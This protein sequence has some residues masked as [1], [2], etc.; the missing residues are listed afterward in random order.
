[1]KTLVTLSDFN[2]IKKSFTEDEIKEKY[3]SLRIMSQGQY[4]EYK[5]KIKYKEMK[6]NE[7]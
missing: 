2:G 4:N 1:M 3:G 5:R 6:G 7:I